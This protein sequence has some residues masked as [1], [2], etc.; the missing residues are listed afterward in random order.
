MAFILERAVVEISAKGDITPQL[1]AQKAKAKAFQIE[2]GQAFAKGV[3]TALVS[4]GAFAVARSL[5]G[6]AS[7]VTVDRLT[8]ATDDLQAVIGRSFVP[9]I[10]KTTG[11][12]RRVADAFNGLNSGQQSALAYGGLIAGGAGIAVGGR[13]AARAVGGYFG[14]AAGPV[15]T[16]AAGATVAAAG[17]TA[18][19]ATAASQNAWLLGT[20][21]TATAAATPGFLARALPWIKSAAKKAGI[22][23]LAY[24]AADLVTGGGLSDFIGNAVSGKGVSSF[25]AAGLGA[26]FSTAQSYSRNLSIAALASPPEKVAGETGFYRQQ[27]E[28]IVNAFA[29]NRW[30]GSIPIG[31]RQ[32]TVA[33]QGG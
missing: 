29:Q 12:V 5:A 24:G 25:G 33:V 8:Q 3:G 23:G 32:T 27:Q 13:Y 31:G 9:A 14:G 16:A 22:A 26:Q 1:A 2:M 21:A 10:E 19:A 17:G 11:I 6:K 7:P 20:A 4:G 28:K 30:I 18:L 15:A